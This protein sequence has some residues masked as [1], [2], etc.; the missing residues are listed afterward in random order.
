MSTL[1]DNRRAR[2]RAFKDPTRVATWA[3][4]ITVGRILL[5]PLLFAIIPDDG[6]SWPAVALWFVL[7]ASDF[8]DGWLARRDGITRAGAY[9]DPL[10][11][12]VLVLGAMFMLVANGAF[13]WLPV[14]IIATRELGISL[15]RTLAGA[16]GISIPAWRLA[17]WKTVAQQLAVGFVLLPLTYDMEWLWQATLWLAVVLT[18]VTGIRYLLAARRI[19]AEQRAAVAQG[20]PIEP[21]AVDPLAGPD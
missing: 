2:V 15:Y 6:G 11:D 19:A 4:V 7:C 9:L 1:D 3:N 21:P 8:L 14:A 10:A 16:K 5:A 13:W 12:K 17:K 20:R 18:V